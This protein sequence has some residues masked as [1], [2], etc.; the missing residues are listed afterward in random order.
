MVCKHEEI[1]MCFASI[2]GYNY[3]V[4]L[5]PPVKIAVVKG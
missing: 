1:Y 5:C 3:Y 4:L 2:V